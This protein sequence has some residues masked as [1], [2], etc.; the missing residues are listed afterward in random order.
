MNLSNASVN[1]MAKL[2]QTY[3]SGAVL[4]FYSGTIPAS[5]DD[6]A[7]GDRLAEITFPASSWS[8]PSA[9]DVHTVA[10]YT[11]SVLLDGTIGYARLTAAT[12]GTLADFGVGVTS[13]GADIELDT[14]DVV[15]GDLLQLNSVTVLVPK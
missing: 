13:S 12:I 9:G 2:F 6:T 5:A 7:T 3:G 4:G 8:V 14:L 10:A 15:A 11:G 1:Y